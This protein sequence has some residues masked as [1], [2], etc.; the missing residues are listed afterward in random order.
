MK[1]IFCIVLAVCFYP[2]VADA[3]FKPALDGLDHEFITHVVANI[4]VRAY[5]DTEHNLQDFQ[6]GGSV[7]RSTEQLNGDSTRS[8]EKVPFRGTLNNRTDAWGAV[9]V[10]ANQV[11]FGFHGSY[12][13]IDWLQDFNMRSNNASSW[14]HRGRVHKGFFDI[15]NC[16]FG[17]LE[18]AAREILGGSEEDRFKNKEII[19]TGH[20]LGGALALLAAARFTANTQNLEPHQVKVITFSS[21]RVGDK[22]FKQSVLKK[23]PLEDIINFTCEADIVR[24]LPFWNTSIGI[25]LKVLPSEQA[26]SKFHMGNHY[27][28]TG[29]VDARLHVYKR[30][31]PYLWP[32]LK[33]ATFSGI[34]AFGWLSAAAKTNSWDFKNFSR[35]FV[36]TFIANL[37]LKT[38][39][40]WVVNSAILAHEVPSKKSVRQSW[41]FLV[42]T[43]Q[44]YLLEN[45]K[46]DDKIIEKIGQALFLRR[47]PLVR[48]IAGL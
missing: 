28:Q 8:W 32:L 43:Y 38:A 48:W 42:S 10:N 25:Q 23:I 3:T 9:Y 37:T 35:I 13:L 16:C 12:W 24:W 2:K 40:D 14:E 45:E 4:A 27:W 15:V 26:L 21:P 29:G 1:V 17:D 7:V 41:S 33:G 30:W 47:N 36:G 44:S 39:W 11:I 34:A 20:S 31:H 18:K 22:E 5:S 46:L 19:F 6:Y